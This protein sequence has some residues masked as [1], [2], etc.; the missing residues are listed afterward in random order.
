VIL[1]LL[2]LIGLLS[3]PLAGGRLARLGELRVR[4]A[5]TAL[6][7]LALQVL[8]VSI[9]PTGQASLHAAVHIATYLLVGAFLWA[10]RQLPGAALVA[11]GA[12]SNALVIVANAGIMPA[13]VA[14]LRVAGLTEGGGFNN[15]AHVAH[16]H[17][18][19]LGDVI[20]VPGPWPVNNV[21]SVGDLLIFAG[22]LFL[23]HRTCGRRA[24]ATLGGSCSM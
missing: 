19:W 20:P 7:A 22:V 8:I 16:P 3:V 14:A 12:G 4:W 9:A 24:P 13:S 6:T 1:I 11:A 23:L 2:A 18:L 17:L 10:N 21:L 5:W 15:S